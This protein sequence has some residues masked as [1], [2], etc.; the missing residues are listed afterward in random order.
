MQLKNYPEQKQDSGMNLQ[1]AEE[2]ELN[3]EFYA[4][5][6]YYSSLKTNKKML[7]QRL[8]V[9]SS[10]QRTTPGEGNEALK[11]RMDFTDQEWAQQR[12]RPDCR[13]D[14]SAGH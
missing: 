12:A 7:K 3:L 14:D 10:Q 11:G 2:K 8:R 9:E 13:D 1:S 5:L 6:K 4:P